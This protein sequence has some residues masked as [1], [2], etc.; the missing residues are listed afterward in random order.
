MNPK[1]ERC[2]EELSRRF[3][4]RIVGQDLVWEKH[5]SSVGQCVETLQKNVAVLEAELTNLKRWRKTSEEKPEVGQLCFVTHGKYYDIC[6]RRFVK[7][8]N[9]WSDNE[10]WEYWLPLIDVPVEDDPQE[11]EVA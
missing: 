8:D 4:C 1:C 10:Y 3:D 2:G 6:G 11:E 5:H 9:W 7:K